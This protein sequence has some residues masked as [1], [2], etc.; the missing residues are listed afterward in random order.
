M[1]SKILETSLGKLLTSAISFG[2][3]SSC[4]S[5]SIVLIL[6]CCFGFFLFDLSETLRKRQNKHLLLRFNFDVLHRSCL[7]KSPQWFSKHLN[8][9]IK[10]FTTG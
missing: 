10:N 1:S 9:L 4:D 5:I 3:L 6:L 8:V 7:L 2:N